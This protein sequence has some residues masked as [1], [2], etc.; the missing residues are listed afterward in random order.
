MFYFK[1]YTCARALRQGVNYTLVVTYTEVAPNKPLWGVYSSIYVGSQ[2]DKVCW[3]LELLC[4]LPSISIVPISGSS[5]R[6]RGP[7]NMKSVWPPLV[8]IFFMTY[9]YRAGGHAP[10]SPPSTTQK[11]QKCSLFCSDLLQQSVVTICSG[12]L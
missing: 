8:A 6:V 11:Y 10:L 3:S 2:R 5:G 9:F 7:R 4:E 1:S 12:I